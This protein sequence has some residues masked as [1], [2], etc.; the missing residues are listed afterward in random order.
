LVTVRATRFFTSRAFITTS[1]FSGLRTAWT[2]FTGIPFSSSLPVL[3]DIEADILLILGDPEAD[4]PV[5]YL[6]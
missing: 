3:G 5:D 1:S 4:G 2:I 6:F